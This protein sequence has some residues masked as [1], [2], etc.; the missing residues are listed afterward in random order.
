V[1][2]YTDDQLAALASRYQDCTALI[3]LP[4]TSGALRYC[5]GDRPVTYSAKVYEPRGM[6]I[7]SMVLDDPQRSRMAVSLDDLDGEL[8][9]AWYDER[10][11][12]KAP[13][14]GSTLTVVLEVNDADV[15]EI[16]WRCRACRVD[17]RG[18]FRIELLGIS[19]LKPR[20]G[21]QTG[22][23]AEF[24]AAPEPGL[25]IRFQNGGFTMPEGYDTPPM[26]G[27]GTG[28]GGGGGTTG[29][30]GNTPFDNPHTQPTA[31]D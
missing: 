8:R 9:A 26:G 24:F 28:G 25:Q 14:S 7:D 30:G 3:E 29:G 10:M 23:R 19:T 27:G 17:R 2:G 11:N 21:L 16:P 18:R 15:I 4:L 31:V 12:L 20:A 22:Q 13:W 6:T 5:T 1:Y